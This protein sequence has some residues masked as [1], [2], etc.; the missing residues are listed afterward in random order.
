MDCTKPSDELE[1]FTCQLYLSKTSATK[2]DDLCYG[3][4]VAKKSNVEPHHLSPCSNA[5]FP[6]QL[7]DSNLEMPYTKARSTTAQWAWLEAGDIET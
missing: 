7:S 5:I 4:F 1:T 2:V 3:L 6:C